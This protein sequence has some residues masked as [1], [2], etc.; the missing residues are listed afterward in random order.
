MLNRIA[1]NPLVNVSVLRSIEWPAAQIAQRWKDISF[2]GHG[3]RVLYVDYGA[4]RLSVSDSGSENPDRFVG[5]LL[6]GD[7]YPLCGASSRYEVTSLTDV[8]YRT[9]PE[10]TF[11]HVVECDQAKM[12][13][14]MQNV[15]QQL[16]R[17]RDLSGRLRRLYVIS[18][19]A[20][21]I[22]WMRAYQPFGHASGRIDF[23]FRNDDLGVILGCAREVASTAITRLE[24]IDAIMFTRPREIRITNESRL[25]ELVKN[26]IGLR[27]G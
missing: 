25:H 3:P 26:G 8:A 4:L 2:C 10:V 5:I 20:D 1:P 23:P 6:P 18:R 11:H 16:E 27:K 12:R 13:A 15:Q 9:L 14:Y 21:F 24:S 22:L 19:L 17:E 7:V